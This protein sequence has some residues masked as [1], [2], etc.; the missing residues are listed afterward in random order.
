MLALPDIDV[1]DALDCDVVTVC[2]PVTNA[3]EQPER[4]HPFDFGGR[5]DAL[6]LDP[7]GFIVAVDG[8]VLQPD[9]ES[10]MPPEAFVF[11]RDHA[12]NCFRWMARPP[13]RILKRFAP[14]SN[15]RRNGLTGK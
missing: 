11:D 13:D 7:S 3:F 15:R 4:W 8:T 1:L 12:A 2:P 5:L 14:G 6:V 9:S 10:R